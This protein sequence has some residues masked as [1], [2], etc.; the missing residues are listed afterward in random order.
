MMRAM[1]SLVLLCLFGAVATAA[2][3][4][5]Y[6]FELTKVLAKD[7]VKPDVVKAA[8]PRLEAQVKKAFETNPQLVPNLE[9]A[10]DPEAEHGEPYRQFLARKGV[11]GAYKVTVEI[12]DATEELTPLEG[13][14]NTQRLVVHIAI[15]VLGETIPGRTMGFTGDGHA[16]VKQ[17]VG[18]KVRDKDRDYA[19]DGAAETAVQDALKT[20]FA[21]LGKGAPRQHN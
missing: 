4:K 11:T 9:G 13:K 1:K 3:T 17:E 14:P 10:P 2:P 8:Q 20:C 16:T 18:M 19:W 6:H 21:Q 5:K 7:N 15:H 12:S